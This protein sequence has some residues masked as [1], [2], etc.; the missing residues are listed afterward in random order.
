MN[1]EA[2]G[3]EPVERFTAPPL[4]SVKSATR[5]ARRYFKPQFIGLDHISPMDPALLV[6]NHTIYGMLDGPLL[7]EKLYESKGIVL[8]SL[9]DHMHF[10]VPFWRDIL[11][12]G[13]AVPGTRDNCA[14]LMEAGE[15]ILV[16][17]GG[18]REVAKR[19]GEKYKLTWKTRTGFCYMAIKYQYPIIPVASLGA[20]DAFDVVLDAYDFMRTPI[21]SS[22]LN[23]KLVRRQT[24]NGDLL[25]PLAK[26]IGPTLI[27]RPEKF[28]FSLG[29]P[30]D[31]RPY[32]G[33]ENDKERVW[34]LRYQVM[35][36]LERELDKLR[37]IRAGDAD[38]SALRRFLTKRK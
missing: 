26:G 11:R 22:I 27:P 4:H 32:A 2:Q 37:V 24:Y 38:V 25:M 21:A 14:R 9:G 1:A 29:T 31:T 35:Q 10:K 13:G 20:D 33:Q 17:P 3:F 16:Y 5:L 12:Q 19:K 15:H 28:Y 6:G 7:F 30:I 34:H 36:S 23:N 8:R 18:G